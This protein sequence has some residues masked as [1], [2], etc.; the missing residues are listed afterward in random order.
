MGY[1]AEMLKLNSDALEYGS[2]QLQFPQATS[3][4][5]R[6]STNSPALPGG[7]STI[8]LKG[9]EERKERKGRKGGR[10]GGRRRK[11]QG[12]SAT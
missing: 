5:T 8:R 11:G 10:G 9:R 2:Y 4:I 12:R 6:E 3:Y 7:D 1:G